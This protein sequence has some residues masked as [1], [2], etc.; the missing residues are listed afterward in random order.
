M[1][2]PD[3]GTIHSWLDGA[4]SADKATLVETHVKECPQCAAAV[5]E[6]RGFIA[7]ASRILTALDNAPRGVIPVAAPK[8]RIDPLA[9]RVAATVLVVAV[10]TLAV[11]R[12]RGSNEQAADRDTLSQRQASV[13]ARVPTAPGPAAVAV[14]QAMPKAVVGN[15]PTIAL[16]GKTGASDSRFGIPAHENN[17]LGKRAMMPAGQ[18]AAASEIAGA[19][20][21]TASAFAPSHVGGV[22][23]TDSAGE[24]KLLK[25]VGTLRR[26]GAK[27]TLYEVVPGDTVTLTESAPLALEQ[28]V[29]TGT[30]SASIARQTAGKSAAAPSRARA[31]MA[32]ITS[33]A[34]SQ[35]AAGAPPSAPAVSAPAPKSLLG[36]AN[37][38][39]TITWTDLATGN[40]LTLT[41]RMPEARLQEIR[42]R[43]ERE[44]ATA[45]AKKS[46]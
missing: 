28:V 27:V 20:A 25:L 2:H 10:G 46:P 42:I 35:R 24:P 38:L 7:G 23:A 14:D 1:Q 26:I 43:I 6:A 17:A 3:E 18:T 9:W 8:K 44:K 40:T 33:A 36:M 29:V 12:N 32:A 15:A 34:D 19:A 5:A 13:A 45:A 41:G 11:L 30:S 16:S 37:T 21:P 31:D 22:V 4:L 39:H